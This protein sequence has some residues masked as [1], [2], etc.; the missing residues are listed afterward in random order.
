M[1][2]TDS[3]D[4]SGNTTVIRGGWIV[5]YNGTEHRILRNGVIVISGDTIKEIG[6]KYNGA[7]DNTIDASNDLVIPGLV[8]CHVHV[9]S[10]AG[11]R[12]ILDEGRRDV[13][14]SGFLNYYP[15]RGVNGPSMS[16]FEDP[17]SVIRYSL[18]SLLRFGST[19]IVEIGAEFSGSPKLFTEIAGELGIR[20]YTC[21]GFNSASHYWDQGGRHHMHWDEDAGIRGLEKAVE[22][23][24]HWDGSYNGRVKG[25]LVP[26]E[27]HASTHDLLRRTKSAAQDLNVGI[28]LHLA[29]SVM[30]YHDTIRSQGKSPIQ[31]LADLEFLG[32]EVILGHCVYIAGHSA[33]AYSPYYQDDLKTLAATHATVAHSPLVFGRRGVALES[34]QR[35]LDAGVN[36]AIGTDSYPQDILDELKFVSILGKVTDRAFDNARARDV[37]NAATLGGAK[38]LGRDDLGRL[39]PGAK[40]DIVIVDLSK[41]RVGPFLD[42]IKALVHCGNGE[43]VDTVMVG[44]KILVSGGAVVDWDEVELLQKVRASADSM[45]QHFSEFHYDNNK[46]QEA[47]P[48][49]FKLW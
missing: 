29:E 33:T 47:Y 11:D 48:P 39:A 35:Y 17:E 7:A 37:F 26:H 28:T 24:R 49:A 22:Y 44:G 45:W 5:A 16:S 32:P 14:R 3:A 1:S 23:I 4:K 43:I 31:V 27:F 20:L 18:A 15:T 2:A 19:T 30:E 40:A 25:I 46:L 34:F 10:M 13:F 6:T 12:M 8:N 42:P 38:A 21:P 41:L 9:S 36:V